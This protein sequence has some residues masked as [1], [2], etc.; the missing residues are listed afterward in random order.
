MKNQ[1]IDA[2]WTP[3]QRAGS[4]LQP[5]GT[6]EAGGNQDGQGSAAVCRGCGAASGGDGGSADYEVMEAYQ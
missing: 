2:D 5:P 4:Q 6:V 3:S 1:I